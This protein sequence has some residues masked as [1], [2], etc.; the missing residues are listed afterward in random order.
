MHIFNASMG[1][2][3]AWGFTDMQLDPNVIQPVIATDLVFDD[4]LFKEI[5]VE[6]NVTA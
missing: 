6:P 4:L 2:G 5:T 1:A 3:L